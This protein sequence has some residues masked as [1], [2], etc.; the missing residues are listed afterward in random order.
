MSTYIAL[1]RGINVLGRNSLLMADLRQLFERQGCRNVR[2]YIQSGNVVFESPADA[3]RR[4]PER[5]AAAVSRTR[6]FE[7]R[8]LVVTR[9]ELR[10]AAARNPFCQE[11]DA[12]PRSLHVFFLARKP[13]RPDLATMEALRAPSERFALDGKA[14]Y[15]HTPDGFGPSR[16]A[17]RVERLLGVD[18]TARNWRTVTTL[19]R[20]AGRARARTP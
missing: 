5:V 1:L 3:A 10:R 6:G 2:T 20:M 15:L 17:D 12:N 13:S 16:L 4:V 11:A 19:L 18:A 9:A 7:P 8:V 14:F